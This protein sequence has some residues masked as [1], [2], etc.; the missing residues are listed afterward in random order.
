MA[1]K[2]YYEAQEKQRLFHR[3]TAQ[4]VLYGGAVGGGKSYAIIWDAVI[5]CLTHDKVVDAIFRRTYPELEK[6]IIL[7]ALK[8]VPTHLYE[9]NKREHRMYFKNGSI[10]EFNYCEFDIDV[11]KYQSAQYDRLHFDELTHFNEFIYKYLISRLRTTV[12]GVIPQ[13]KSASNPGNVGHGWVKDRFIED[14]IPGEVTT[15]TNPDTGTTFTTQFIP[16]K[17]IDNERLTENDPEYQNR[18]MN[19]PREYRHMLLE[20]DWD[21]AVGQYFKEWRYDIHVIEP[22]E[23]PAFWTRVC[24]L[25]WGFARPTVIEWAAVSPEGTTYIYRELSKKEHTDRDIAI[26]FKEA[27]GRENISY[28]AT[29][30][31]LWSRTQF[32][33]GESIAMRLI[34]QGLKLI[35]GDNNRIAGWNVLRAYLEHDETHPPKIQIFNTCHHII[36]TLPNLVHDDKRPE[37]LDTRGDDDA[38][39]SLRY[40]LMSRPLARKKGIV[41][42]PVYSFDY[43]TRRQDRERAKKGYVGTL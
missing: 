39:D 40:L 3:A 2:V 36:R 8:K 41:P 20:G 12:E 43:W 25:D 35:R 33:R 14:A 10:I 21:V 16:A 22:F 9:Y 32:E 38:A 28:I 27:T 15:R 6:S 19:L 34:Q 29:D 37:D 24:G 5:F 1:E 4:E 11:Y 13:V 31:S 7:E 23:I 26:K 42:S 18:L 30:P 17:L